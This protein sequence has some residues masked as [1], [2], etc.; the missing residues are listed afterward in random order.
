LAKKNKNSEIRRTTGKPRFFLFLLTIISLVLILSCG[1]KHAR[2]DKIGV[3]VS[4]LPLADFVQQIGKDKVDVSVM[5]PPGANPHSYEPKPDQLGKV[6]RARMFVKVGSGVEFEL[7]WMDKLTE[8]NRGM[9]IV[10]SSLGIELMGRDPHIWLSP[11]NAKRM[12]EN[13]L[14]GLIKLDPGN[15]EHY[16]ANLN[17]YLGELDEIDQYIRKRLAGIKNRS[18]MVYHS[19]WSYF[20]RDYDLEQIS[21]EYAGKEP[22]ALGIKNALKKAKGFDNKVVFV[23]P[24]FATKGMETVAKQIGG[25]IEVIDPLPQTYI[26]NLQ[27]VMEK[28]AQVMR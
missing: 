3:V 6:S 5:I 25:T 27:M 9:V 12:V 10:N 23:S 22:T 16:R 19:A 21:I 18:F 2:N 7:V 4:I 11:S 20:A 15:Q 26:A 14:S 13:I 17:K 28:L 8:I 24:Q 1:E